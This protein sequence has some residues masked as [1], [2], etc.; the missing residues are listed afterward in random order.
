MNRIYRLVFNRTTGLMQVASELA[1]SPSSPS[2]ATDNR[3]RRSPLSAAM[4]VAL[5]LSAASLPTAFAA[6][7]DFDASET[8]TDSRAYVDGFRVGPNGAVEVQL[9]NGG[10]FTSNGLVSL[11]T[12][13]GSNGELQ[14]FGPTSSLTVNSAVVR[15]GEAG[16]RAPA[17]SRC[18]VQVPC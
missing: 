18:P 8:V 16:T 12:L 2:P 5:G 10:T 13:A 11:G 15:V 9:R 14:I 17:V 6:V 4:L 7:Y 1:T 3:R